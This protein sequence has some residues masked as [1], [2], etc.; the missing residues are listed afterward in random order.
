MD[1]K[2]NDNTSFNAKLS[3]AS[4]CIEHSDRLKNTRAIFE[5]MTKD[6]AGVLGLV[7]DNNSK[8]HIFRLGKGHV[9]EIIPRPQTAY[10]SKEWFKNFIYKKS[11]NEKA[12]I[13]VKIFDTLQIIPKK[14]DKY[15]ASKEDKSNLINKIHT[16]LGEDT[17]GISN[18]FNHLV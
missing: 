14:Y 10:T 1:L 7:Y 15:M 18:M 3:I 5:E 13:L 6:K 12:D 9:A 8:N 11:D 2:I 16:S 4:N 17:E